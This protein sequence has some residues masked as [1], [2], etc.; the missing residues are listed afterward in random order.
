METALAIALLAGLTF[1][2]LLIKWVIRS[3]LHKGFD[4]AE[5]AYKRAQEKKNP[6]Q[7]ESLADRYRQNGGSF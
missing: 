4:A 5:N 7:A 1:V 3:T 6:P 2:L